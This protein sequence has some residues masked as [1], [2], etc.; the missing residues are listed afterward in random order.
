MAEMV[1]NYA[2][3]CLLGIA[4]ILQPIYGVISPKSYN[5]GAV[6]RQTFILLKLMR[7]S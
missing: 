5:L 2:K 1:Q 7:Q 3:L 4:L 6:N